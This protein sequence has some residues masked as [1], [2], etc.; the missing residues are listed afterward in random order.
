MDDGL[1]AAAYALSATL[2]VLAVLLARREPDHRPFAAYAIWMPTTD[3]VRIGLRAIRASAPDPEAGIGRLTHHL[4]EALVLSWSF[5]LLAVVLLAFTRLRP[6]PALVGWAVAMVVCLD[7]GAVRFEV[8]EAVYRTVGVACMGLGLLAVA[9]ALVVRRD[10]EPKLHHLALMI[11]LSGEVVAYLFPFVSN[12]FT[13]WSVVRAINIVLLV[14][15]CAMHAR[16]LRTG[17]RLAT[18]GVQ[19]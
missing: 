13:D 1:R 18:Q 19:P 16:A 17:A 2:A 7:R 14:V 10:I 11:A 5:A 6:W 4:G 3:W 8:L 12:L 15:L 9:W